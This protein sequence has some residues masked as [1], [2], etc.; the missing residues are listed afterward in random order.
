MHLLLLVFS[1]S[2]F[3]NKRGTVVNTGTFVLLFISDRKKRIMNKKGDKRST[4]GRYEK[5]LLSGDRN[6]SR[7][8]QNYMVAK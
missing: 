3:E 2:F 5:F 6:S 8:L 7:V 1:F 4:F